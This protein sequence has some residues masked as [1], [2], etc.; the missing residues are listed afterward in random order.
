MVLPR[1]QEMCP[2]NEFYDIGDSIFMNEV[3]RMID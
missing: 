2:V 1:L 3:A